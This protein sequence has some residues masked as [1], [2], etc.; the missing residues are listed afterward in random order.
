[1]TDQLINGTADVVTS[2]VL[3]DPGT[4]KWATGGPLLK[5]GAAAKASGRKLH[6]ISVS[7]E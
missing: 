6:Y 2:V 5:I 3:G 1:M 4:D 7:E